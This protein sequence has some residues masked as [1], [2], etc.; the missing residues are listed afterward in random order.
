V[1]EAVD[2]RPAAE[3]EGQSLAATSGWP[4]EETATSEAYT[5]GVSH[6]A[7]KHGRERRMEHVRRSVAVITMAQVPGNG[8]PLAMTAE[9]VEAV[10]SGSMIV[11]RAWGSCAL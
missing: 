1:V 4:L 8:A 2:I 11:R 7:N 10:S 6:A 9:M 3:A 5:R